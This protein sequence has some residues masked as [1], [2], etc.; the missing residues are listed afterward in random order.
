MTRL[1]SAAVTAFALAAVLASACANSEKPATTARPNA[2][3][4]GGGATATPSATP[5]LR[6]DDRA[7]PSRYALDLTLVPEDDGFRG[8]AQIDVE[9]TRPITELW[10]NGTDLQVHQA[11]IEFGGKRIPARVIPGKSEDFL[12]LAVDGE[13]GQPRTI[14]PGKARVSIDY[15]GRFEEKDAMGIFKQKEGDHFYL[16]TQFESIGARRAFPSFDEPRFK[17]PFQ[18]T[19][20][21]KSDQLAASNTLPTAEEKGPEQGMKT[22]RFAETPPLPSYLVAFVVGPFDAVDIGAGGRNQIPMRILTPRGKAAETAYAAKVTGPILAA[23]EDYFDIAY[24]YSKLDS[25]AVPQFGGAMENPGLITYSQWLILTKPGE[26]TPRSQR[27][28][29]SVAAHEIAHQWFGNLVTTA[30]WE[31]IW[32]NEAFATWLSSKVITAWK[33]EWHG[34]VS[35][36]SSRNGSMDADSLITAR[37]IRQPIESNHDIYNAFD[38]ITYGK[39]AAVIAMFESWMGEEAFRQAMQQYMHEHAFG[40]ATAADFLAAIGRV[41]HQNVPKAFE[42]FLDQ[43]GVPLVAVSL[44]CQKGKPPTIELSQER[45]LPA[46]SAGEK[47]SQ[48]WQV[49]VCVKYGDGRKQKR[50]C[51]LLTECKGNIALETQRCPEWVLANSDSLGYYRASYGKELLAKLLRAERKLS[52][53]ERIGVVGDLRALVRAGKADLGQALALVPELLRDRNH[54]VA[55]QA[56]GI[57]GAVSEMVPEAQRIRYHRFLAK[58]FG[59]R[60]RQLGWT[61]RRGDEDD[62]RLLRPAVLELAAIEGEDGVLL[63]QARELASRWLEDERALT[64]DVRG[65]V[66]EA[67]ALAGDAELH[68]RFYQAAKAEKERKRRN[69]LI[70]AFGSFRQPELVQKNI[71]IAMSDEFDFREAMSLIQIPLGRPETRELVYSWIKENYDRLS[72]KTPRLMRRYLVYSAVPFC[73]EVHKKDA[74]AFFAD[75]AEAIPGGPRSFAQAMEQIKLCIAYREAQLPGLKAFLERY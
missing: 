54:Q 20:H 57:A 70:A 47:G 46:G 75:K 1:H 66:L 45:F 16:F 36:A 10:L 74:E 14:G 26:E 71:E 18:V 58:T 23:L 43:P 12:G 55:M 40:V 65:T 72:Q 9:I 42:T 49:P 52:T 27:S 60:A 11:S 31:D 59:K 62:V 51:T 41:S 30:W 53:A 64:P 37:K 21:V 22:L 68:Q 34:E 7:K 24:P 13:H 32:L 50:Q 69:A 39:G 48:L 35:A 8:R 5:K 2:A 15:S 63:K 56:V 3:A 67:A 6:L 25:V 28:Y 19:L 38:G 44:N 17:V 29:A 4:N 33:P 73:D 61:H